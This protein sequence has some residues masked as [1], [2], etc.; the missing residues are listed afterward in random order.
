MLA[1]ATDQSS[2]AAAPCAAK[3]SGP[4][5]S[6]LAEALAQKAPSGRA[7]WPSGLPINLSFRDPPYI[8]I[9]VSFLRLV[10]LFPAGPLYG[11]AVSYYY[12]YFLKALAPYYYR[13]FP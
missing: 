10:G 12:A 9:S 7:G 3:A 11:L 4:L 13:F 2:L 6:R 8:D 5:I 1:Q